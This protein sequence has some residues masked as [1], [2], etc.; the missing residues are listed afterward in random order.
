MNPKYAKSSNSF[1]KAGKPAA[2]SVGI[3]ARGR[4]LREEVA[5]A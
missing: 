2:K 1:W 4:G 3:W 5:G